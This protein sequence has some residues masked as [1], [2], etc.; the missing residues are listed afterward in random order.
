MLVPDPGKEPKRADGSPET[1]QLTI[2]R[3]FY[4]I[5]GLRTRN[6]VVS[7]SRFVGNQEVSLD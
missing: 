1:V 7:S 2:I 5:S 6:A 3:D 4:G